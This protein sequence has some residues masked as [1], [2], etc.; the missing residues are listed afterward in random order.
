M[1]GDPDDFAHPSITRDDG[2]LRA[3][4]SGQGKI[5]L[6]HAIANARLAYLLDLTRV[7]LDYF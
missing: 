1:S 5:L 7:A 3:G 4:I 2:L 6:S